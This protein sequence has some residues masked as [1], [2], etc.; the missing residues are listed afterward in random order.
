MKSKFCC[1][2]RLLLML[3]LLFESSLITL[4]A[5]L[6]NNS[7]PTA[8]KEWNTGKMLQ[9]EK[10][11]IKGFIGDE[12]GEPI[13]GATVRER[14]SANAAIT[15]ADGTF[16][17]KVLPNA[18]LDIAYIGYQNKEIR[19]KGRT[20]IAISMIPNNKVLD[21]VVVVGFGKQKKESLVGAVQS[22]KPQD[23]KMTSSS[24]TTSF[25]GNVPGIIARQTTGEPGYDNAE[26]YIRGVSTFGA[27][28]NPLIILDGV[29]ISATMLKL[30]IVEFLYALF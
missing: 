8:A 25:A 14:G 15:D 17:L 29:E 20:F 26:F 13:V 2:Q 10:T 19:L 16:S 23:L 18:T 30:L 24:L 27:N 11:A 7:G 9:N 21:E 4:Q 28:K 12:N 3:L 5:E 1:W 6:L 22:V